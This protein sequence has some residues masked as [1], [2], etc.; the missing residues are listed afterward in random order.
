MMMCGISNVQKS[1]FLGEIGNNLL[2][3]ERMDMLDISR[4][5]KDLDRW[6]ACLQKSRRSGLGNLTSIVV[7]IV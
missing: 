3:K 4:V 1:D 5:C 7:G 6:P 2:L